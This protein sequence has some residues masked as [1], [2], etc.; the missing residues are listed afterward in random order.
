MKEASSR[1][2]PV[3]HLSPE[4]MPVM[5]LQTIPKLP[6]CQESIGYTVSIPQS[7]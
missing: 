4:F 6:P 7:L 5:K 1:T 2:L 3:T